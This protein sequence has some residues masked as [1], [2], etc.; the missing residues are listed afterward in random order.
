MNLVA[1][2]VQH[3]DLSHKSVVPICANQQ[4]NCQLLVFA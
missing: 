2:N 1:L 3:E 4:Q